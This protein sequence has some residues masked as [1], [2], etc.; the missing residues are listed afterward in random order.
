MV[1]HAILCVFS[2]HSSHRPPAALWKMSR[3]ERPKNLDT[4]Q[5][6]LLLFCQQLGGQLGWFLS[7]VSENG[8]VV[9]NVQQWT[10]I[11]Q[12]RML[13]VCCC[14][15]VCQVLPWSASKTHRRVASYSRT[16]SFYRMFSGPS[17]SDFTRLMEVSVTHWCQDYILYCYSKGYIH[18][19]NCLHQNIQNIVNKNFILKTVLQWVSVRNI[20]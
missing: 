16:W 2:R 7:W 19:V 8:Y 9:Q 18:L 20:I 1:S 17:G 13:T 5:R 3:T 11:R 12:H 15:C 14:G 4:I 6:P 10:T